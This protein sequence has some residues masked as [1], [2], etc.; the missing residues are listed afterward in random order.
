MAVVI[1]SAAF[2]VTKFTRA[3][4]RGK[5]FIAFSTAAGVSHNGAAVVRAWT[6]RALSAASRPGLAAGLFERCVSSQTTADKI[7]ANASS[8]HRNACAA[9]RAH[10]WS[11]LRSITARFATPSRPGIFLPGGHYCCL[12]RL[13]TPL[14]ATD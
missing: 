9:A 6:K 1:F 10:L 13:F 14:Y 12:E 2:G 4:P 7:V 11:A 3:S 5:D 8:A